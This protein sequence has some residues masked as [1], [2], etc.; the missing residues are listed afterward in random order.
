MPGKTLL[1]L[2]AA[3]LLAAQAGAQGARPQAPERLGD[4]WVSFQEAGEDFERLGVS[5]FYGS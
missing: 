3:T 4:L 2:V 1:A 5:L